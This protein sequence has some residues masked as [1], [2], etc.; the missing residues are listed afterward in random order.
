[1]NDETIDATTN[2]STGRSPAHGDTLT[3]AHRWVQDAVVLTVTGDLDM[4]TAPA[5]ADAIW[6]A[7]RREPTAL[8]VDLLTVTFLASAGMTLLLTARA[9]MAPSIRF[10][11]VADGPATSRPLKMLGVDQIVPLYRTLPDAMAEPG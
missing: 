2:V 3:I 11:V 9:E 10:G 8:I 1:M 6:A 4:L 5:L 7:A